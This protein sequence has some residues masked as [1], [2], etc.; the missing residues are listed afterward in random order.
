MVEMTAL[1]LPILLSAVAVYLA[2]TV[3]HMMLPYHKSDYQRL[4]NEDAVMDALRTAGVTPG[5]YHFPRCESHK[6]MKDP[7]YVAKLNKGPIGLMT[8]MP[9]GM[10]NMVM[11]LVPWFLYCL[12]ISAF[13][14]Y[15]ASHFLPAGTGYRQLFRVA[16]LVAFLSYGMAHTH[17]SIW[18][19]R[20]WSTTLKFWFD[21]VIYASLTAGVFTWLWPK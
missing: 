20:A 3:I 1:W 10:P 2:G 15:L 17:I 8:I 16:G 9:N 19:G 13:V 14:A 18:E 7:A 11:Y 5:T 21:A 12:A 6:D 4:P